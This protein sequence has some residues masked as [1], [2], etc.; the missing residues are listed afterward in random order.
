MQP[1][2]NVPIIRHA[3]AIAAHAKPAV[4]RK[5]QAG[6]D[7]ECACEA[8]VSDPFT[9]TL[10]RIKARQL[11]RRSDFSR[12]DCDDLQQQ[13]RLYLLE[14]AQL[15]DPKRGNL[16]AF[17]TRILR[18]WVAMQLRWRS[19]EKRRESYKALSLERTPVEYEGGIT[20][21][22]AVLLEEDGR[23]LSR[24]SPISNAER[25]ELNEA[26]AHALQNLTPQ[27]RAL[28]IQVAGHDVASAARAFGVSRRRINNALTRA[29]AQFKKSGLCPDS[30]GHR[31]P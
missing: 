23:R 14:K 10:I 9:V 3:A 22:G 1:S 20:S 19:R 25:F 28:L 31:A 4:Q 13:M 8:I 21:L 29:R 18:T 15:F 5:T 26:I 7:G 27:D 16:E 30:S 6:G 11:C 17:V 24:T 2:H 12:S